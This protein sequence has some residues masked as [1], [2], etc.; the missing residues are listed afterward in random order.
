V[1]NLHHI[2]LVMAE[3][4]MAFK[5]VLNICPNLP[6]IIAHMM[7]IHVGISVRTV[8]WTS[9]MTDWTEE[10]SWGHLCCP[11]CLFPRN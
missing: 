11:H 7:V 6:I 10:V 4:E 8:S 2:R 1:Q 5:P 3:N 9:K